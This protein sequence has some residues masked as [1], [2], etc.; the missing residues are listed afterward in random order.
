MEHNG[1]TGPDSLFV[2]ARFG[3]DTIIG[4]LDTGNFASH[5]LFLPYGNFVIFYSGSHLIIDEF[6]LYFRENL[7]CGI[8]REAVLEKVYQK[9][10]N[11]KDRNDP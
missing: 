5:I 11:L 1:L 7:M 10:I 3:E 6:K 4:H 9:E 2:K 8:I